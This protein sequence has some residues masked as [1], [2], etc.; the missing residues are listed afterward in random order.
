MKLEWGSL[1]YERQMTYPNLLLVTL[2]TNLPAI[3]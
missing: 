3:F 1:R 2:E